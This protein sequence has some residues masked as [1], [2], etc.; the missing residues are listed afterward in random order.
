MRQVILFIFCFNTFS[1]K[2]W[3]DTLFVDDVK[4]AR[5]L[6]YLDSLEA[7]EIG[8][9]VAKNVADTLKSMY[10][11]QSLEGYF[12]NKYGYEGGTSEGYFFDY[13]ENVQ[14]EIGHVNVQYRRM[15]NDSTFPWGFLEDQ[16][17]RLNKIKIQ[18]AGIMSGAEL[19]DVFVYTKPTK[20]VAFKIVKRFTVVG[21]IIKFAV[22]ND[23]KTK[24]PYIEKLYYV[25]DARKH[26]IIDSIEKLDPVTKKHLDF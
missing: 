9:S 15:R 12:L 4:D 21:Q 23:G 19:P 2:A 10:G 1:A 16:Y 6:L 17:R 25:E 24:T 18:P 22:T 5:Y 11:N 13:E 20:I 14:V 7:Y 3:N 26:Q 8:Y